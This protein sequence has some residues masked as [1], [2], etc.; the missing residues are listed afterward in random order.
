[1]YAIFIPILITGLV[2]R[3]YNNKLKHMI[4]VQEE[5][6]DTVKQT[7]EDRQNTTVS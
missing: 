3:I 7:T 6:N 1:M 4:N 5:Q 2:L